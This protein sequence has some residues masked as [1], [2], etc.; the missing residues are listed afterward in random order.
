MDVVSIFSTRGSAHQQ[1]RSGTHVLVT[2]F[3]RQSPWGFL[4]ALEHEL[5]LAATTFLDSVADRNIVA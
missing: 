1:D 5:R 2:D 3:A 4:V